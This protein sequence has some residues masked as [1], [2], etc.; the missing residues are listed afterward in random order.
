[1]KS[2]QLQTA[3]KIEKQLSSEAHIMGNYDYPGWS[4]MCREAAGKIRELEAENAQLCVKYALMLKDRNLLLDR[5]DG[6]P[7]SSNEWQIRAIRAE[8]KLREM[9]SK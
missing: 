6:G 3:G 5:L 2:E 4:R 9:E 1:M 7:L 8:N